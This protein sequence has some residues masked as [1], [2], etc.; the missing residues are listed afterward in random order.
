MFNRRHIATLA[1]AAIML[2]SLP[3]AEAKEKITVFAAA[4]LKTAL[5]A[6]NAAWTAE[7]GNEATISYAASSA[8]PNRSSKARRPMS[9][10][11]PIS[12]GWLI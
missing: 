4:S 10:S 7:T 8:L 5:D 9:S 1:A 2:V 6:V 3:Q 11:P 12:T